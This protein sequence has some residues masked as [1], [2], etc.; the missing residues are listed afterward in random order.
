MID[1]Q[2]GKNPAEVASERALASVFQCLDQRKHFCLEAGAGAGKTYTLVKALQYLMDRDEIN[3][4]RQHQRVACITFTNVAKAE[5]EA[6]TDRSPLIHCDTIHAFCWSLIG[7]FQ[8]QVRL[9]LPNIEKWAEILAEKGEIGQR[10]IKYTL[11]Y[12]GVQDDHVTLH[13][14]D[15]IAIAVSLLHSPKFGQLIKDRYPVILIDEYQDTNTEWI[16]AITSELMG[17]EYSPQFGFFGDH[18]Q[19]IY[20]SG[21]G[22]VDHPSI[23][24]IG[25]GA[26]FRSRNAIVACLNRIRP[27]LVQAVVDPAAE[28][29]VRVMHTNGWKGVRQTGQHWK[30]DLPN[31]QLDSAMLSAKRRL[32]DDGW[33]FSAGTTKILMLTH[34][35]LAAQQGYSSLPGIFKFNE[36]F[37][38]KEHPHIAFFSD[39]LEPCCTAF[40]S[41]RYGEMFAIIGQKM[42]AIRKH[43]DKETWATSMRRVIELREQGTVGEVIDHLRKTHRPRLPEALEKRERE[44]EAFKAEDGVEMSR[45]LVE[46]QDLRAVQYREIIA[47][48]LYLAGHSPFETK[49]GVKGA[50]FENVLII[51]GRGWNHYDFNDFL[52][53]AQNPDA[54]PA[55]KREAFE[56]N[57]NLF[58]VACS[59]PKVRLALLFTQL[60]SESALATIGDWFGADSIE[61]L[62]FSH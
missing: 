30:G 12:R 21:C 49:H 17:K 22:T 56:R 59:R 9:Q 29:S 5:I 36:A 42:P 20:G 37:A 6:R 55:A 18:W 10:E 33:D 57:R 35:V 19:K 25:K 62:E 44:L 45:T 8:H 28:G 31:E 26:N 60:L 52:E 4:V 38:K 2:E 41:Q 14:D 23:V 50:E 46:L 15:V 53:R 51:L 11:G 13:H 16:A 54:V 34:R 43:A 3:L 7:R 47:L 27:M 24:T 40:L 1:S 39:I 32:Q 61:S 48:S 58:Y